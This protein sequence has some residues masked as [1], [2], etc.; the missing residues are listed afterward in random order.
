MLIPFISGG[1]LLRLLRLA[2]V[3][4]CLRSLVRVVDWCVSLLVRLICCRII[5]CHPSPS[6]TTFAFRS[7]VVIRL[8]LDLDPY[9]V[10]DALGMFHFFLM[11]TADV[12]DPS[13]CSV[14]AACSS[15]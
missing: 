11:R 13:L 15:G 10:T 4:N 9:G 12:I 6:L 3:H 8:L 14:S 2:Q 1:P 5:S 7:S